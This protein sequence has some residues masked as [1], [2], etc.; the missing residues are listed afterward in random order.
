MDLDSDQLAAFPGEAVG[1]LMA[2]QS[3]H[4]RIT[5]KTVD[6]SQ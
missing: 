3:G 6:V 1:A 2:K 4:T 5:E